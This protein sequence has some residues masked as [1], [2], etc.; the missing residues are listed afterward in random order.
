MFPPGVFSPSDAA[1]K[2]SAAPFAATGES[3][4]ADITGT[5]TCCTLSPSELSAEV[6][7]TFPSIVFV[8]FIAGADI[9]TFAAIIPAT[10]AAHIFFIIFLFSLKK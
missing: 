1:P 4:D 5:T 7:Y 2:F 8:C 6:W 3:S 9:A 10:P